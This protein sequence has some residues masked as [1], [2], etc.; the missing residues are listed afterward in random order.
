MNSIYLKIFVAFRGFFL[1]GLRQI[2]FYRGRFYL[3][4]MSMV[5]SISACNKLVEVDTPLIYTSGGDAFASDANAIAVLNGIYANMSL[6]ALSDGSSINSFM[7]LYPGLSADEFTLFSG[8]TNGSYIAF[9]QNDLLNTSGPNPWL[10]SYPVIYKLN[11]AINGINAS[12][13][14]SEKVKSQLLGEAKFLRAFYYFYLVNLYGP[15]PLVLTVNYK[16][17]SVLARSSVDAVYQQVVKD[18]VEAEGLLNENFVGSNG[19]STSSERVVPNKWAAKALLAR[20]YLYTKDYKDAVALST[21]VINNSSLFSLTDLNSVFL[22][23]SQEAIWQLQPV[24]LGWN[25]EDAKL[26][27]IPETGPSEFNPV[28]LS[29]SLLNSFEVNDQ[30]RINWVDTTIADGVSYYFPYKYKSATLNADVT[31]YK[32]VL[33]LAEQYLIRAEA[34]AQQNNLSAA[35]DDLNAIRNR[36]GLADYAG[37]NNQASLLSAILHERR[38]ELFSEWGNRWLDLKRL[39]KVDEVMSVYSTV[40]GGTWNSYDQYYPIYQSELT[41][42]PNLV[43]NEGY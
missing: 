2:E 20:V 37:G 24:N 39:S 17:N 32:M 12:S 29:D 6:V 27:V 43:Q 3:L 22:S 33:R 9:Y 13:G 16:E 38:I 23:N 15:V 5:F 40:K 14:I 4:C 30:R 8:V 28:Y 21:E 31:E 11:D 18:L 41:N 7:S 26:F 42:D 19:Y 25:T 34:N 10:T 36:A 35:A 1:T